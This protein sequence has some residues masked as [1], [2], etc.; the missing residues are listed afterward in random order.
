MALVATRRATV[1]AVAAA[2]LATTVGVLPLFLLGGL[3]VFV[4]ADLRFGAAELGVAVATYYAA[5]A[6]A[7]LPAGW[8]AERIGA[9]RSMLLGAAASTASLLAIAI[10]ASD[11]PRLV[12]TMLLAGAGNAMSQLGANLGLA[13]VVPR[14]R[15]GLAFGIK[16]ASIPVATLLA[17][18]AVPLLGLTV[19]W[20]WAFAAGA[21]LF[22]VLVVVAPRSEARPARRPGSLRAG[23]VTLR[24]LV[25]LAIA[26][27]LG[28]A[29]VNALGAFFVKSTVASGLDVGSAGFLLALASVIGVAAR[30]W[31]GHRA[32]QRAGGHLNQVALLI[33]IGGLAMALLALSEI[34]PL[35]VVA[36]VVA[37]GAGWGWNGLFTFAIVRRNPRA[38]AAATAIT[39]LGLFLGGVIGPLAFGA[40]VEGA[41]YAVAWLGGA[42]ALFV[43]AGL[44][45]VGRRM[46]LVDVA[47]RAAGIPAG[48][49]ASLDR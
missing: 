1:A 21:L 34:R 44:I 29:S 4:G 25:V 31:N 32:D 39:Q 24:P 16:Q 30:V 28:S 9:R 15:Q 36:S 33:V 23:D 20:R 12:A 35:L 17:G 27:A 10:A 46:V 48:T 18:L 7:S 47:D 26:A 13:R 37:F 2:V 22:P 42:L 11:L 14:D 41:S 40:T 43:A 8:F 5:S 49:A 3:A 6:V 45:L 19:G 38:P